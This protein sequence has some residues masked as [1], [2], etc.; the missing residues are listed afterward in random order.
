M[1]EAS[2]FALL[3][4]LA[5]LTRRYGLDAFSE[6]ASYLKNREGILELA[7][8]LEAAEEAGRKSRVPRT[9]VTAPSSRSSKS[10]LLSMLSKLERE[11]PEKAEVL[12][13]FYEALATK[14]ALPT[15]GAL[16]DFAHDNGLR[17]ISAKS[18]DKAISPLLRDLAGRPINHIRSM[19][20][21]V[22]ITDATVGDRSLEGWAD[23]ILNKG[24]LRE[25]S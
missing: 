23:V 25:S 11:D 2:K 7:A 14:R 10:S 18:R 12:S 1:S 15:L 20:G 16:R 19:L 9:G 24:K 5:V 6:L 13:R 17:F 3:R 21:R 22:A 8:I 4:D